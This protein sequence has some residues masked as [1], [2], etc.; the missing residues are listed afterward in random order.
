MKA[1]LL[2]TAV[3][4]AAFGLTPA[5]AQTTIGVTSNNG[6]DSGVP[7]A[8][9]SGSVTDNLNGTVTIQLNLDPAGQNFDLFFH[10]ASSAGHPTIGFDLGKD[11]NNTSVLGADLQLLSATF[12]DANPSGTTAGLLLLNVGQMDGTGTWQ[13]GIDCNTFCQANTTHVTSVSFT[14]GDTLQGGL[15]LASLVPNAAGNLLGLTVWSDTS[16]TAGNGLTGFASVNPVAAV[17]EPATW[18]MMLLGFI[19][20]GFAFRS[21]RRIAG[22]A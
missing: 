5:S 1:K 20:L 15:N 13:F 18:A 6:F 17:P 4:L 16:A 8:A 14:L 10:G 12:T 21:R 19:G 11:I 7:Q 22:F 9:G 2:L 3:A